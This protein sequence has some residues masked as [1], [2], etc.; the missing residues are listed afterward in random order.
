MTLCVNDYDSRVVIE[1]SPK[2]GLEQLV[3]LS[4]F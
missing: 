2:H 1:K 4:D 3:Y